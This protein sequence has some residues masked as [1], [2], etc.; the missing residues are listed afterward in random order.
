M[1]EKRLAPVHPGEVL[2][3]DFLL[4]LELSP[5][6]VARAC[7]VPR[8]RIERHRAGKS[9]DHRR[10]GA[11]FGAFFGTR[12]AF[13]MNI[14]AQFD[15]ESAA[16]HLAADIARIEPLKHMRHSGRHPQ[17]KSEYLL[18]TSVL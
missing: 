2:R 1:E 14:Q 4:P 7:G 13:W 15:L 12:P 5:Y 16:D 10:L 17:K 9:A 11:A 18:V 3:E 8:T 6:A